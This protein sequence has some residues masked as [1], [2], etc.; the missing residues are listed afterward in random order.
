MQIRGSGNLLIDSLNIQTAQTVEVCIDPFCSGIERIPLTGRSQ[1]G[2]VTVDSTGNL[3]F[4]NSVIQSDTLSANPAGNISMTT[5]GILTFDN[6]QITSDTSGIGN[7][8]SVSI[9]APTINLTGGS[10]IQAE[11]KP[12]SSGSGGDITLNAAKIVSLGEQST[13]ST[14]TVGSGQG[15]D[16]TLS[17]GDLLVM[18]NSSSITTNARAEGNGGNI[19][20]NSPDGFLVSVPQENSDITANAFNG[21]GGQVTINAQGI[22]WFTPRSRADLVQALG[23]SDP[24]QLD[25][26]QLPT[27]DITAISQDN[28]NLSGIVTL[29]TLNVDP[30]QGLS[31]LPTTPVDPSNQIAQECTAVGGSRRGQFVIARRG[32]LPANPDNLFTG[33][34][35]VLPDLMELVPPSTSNPKTSTLPTQLPA[36]IVEA[37]GWTVDA[38]G[39]IILVAQ[40]NS[41]DLYGSGIS[42]TSCVV[43]D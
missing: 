13:I 23:T 16:I 29:N 2:N 41:A 22:Y 4:R 37:Q 40:T 36:K 12:G 20:I 11:T 17:V 6:T 19:L 32:G 18:R 28:P 27:N 33:E 43:K 9:T 39:T 3:T 5:P 8:G 24:A 10:K 14:N 15:G 34:G 42:R 25:P 31:E 26:S 21:R 38:D 7:A 35:E 1:A 30:S